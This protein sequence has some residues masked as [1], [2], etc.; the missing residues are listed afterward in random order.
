MKRRTAG[1]PSLVEQSKKAAKALF[2]EAPTVR[3]F[4]HFGREL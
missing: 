1:L 3:V 4:H 2:E